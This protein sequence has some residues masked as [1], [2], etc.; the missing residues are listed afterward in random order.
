MTQTDIQVNEDKDTQ[1]ENFD[2]QMESVNAPIETVYGP[3]DKGDE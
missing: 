2:D 1:T 3:T